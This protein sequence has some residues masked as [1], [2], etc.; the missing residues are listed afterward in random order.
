MAQNWRN[1]VGLATV[2]G[3]AV[4]LLAIPDVIKS[5]NQQSV[6]DGGVL[7]LVGAITAVLSVVLSLRASFGWPR[8]V[9]VTHPWSLELWEIAETVRSIWCLRISVFLAGVSIV[10]LGFACAVLIFHVALPVPWR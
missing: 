1:G 2:L 6:D 7:L 8:R 9:D 3:G 4:A 5:A 10:A